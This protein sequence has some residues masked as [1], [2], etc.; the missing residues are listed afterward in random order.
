M[1]FF[2]LVGGLCADASQHKNVLHLR[3]PRYNC[4]LADSI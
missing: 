4:R 3:A 2:T 1:Y